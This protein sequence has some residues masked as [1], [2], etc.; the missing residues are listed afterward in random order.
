MSL[1]TGLLAVLLSA[2]GGQAPA[3]PG[4][5]GGAPPATAADAVS[6]FEAA[7]AR[8]LQGDYPGAVQGYERIVEAG[9]AS[10][11]LFYNLG[12]AYL[13]SGRNGWAIL[14]YERALRIAPGDADVRA[15]LE[16][17]RSASVDRLVG[18]GEEAFLDR[19]VSRLPRLESTAAFAVAW[20]ALW[21]LL[22]AHRRAFGRSRALLGAVTLAA[23]LL[24]TTSGGFLALKARAERIPQAVVVAP[25]SPVREAPG[26]ALKPAFE[27]HEGTKVRVLEASGQYLRVRLANGLEGW[28]ARSEVAMI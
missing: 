15:N 1:G 18:A 23:A 12:N 16:L 26:T 28:L 25:V 13:R 17:A 21:G 14:S 19:L 24:A 8:Y 5:T 9:F 11:P 20:I 22:L 7:G 4:A 10:A 2:G 27:L 6:A 3:L